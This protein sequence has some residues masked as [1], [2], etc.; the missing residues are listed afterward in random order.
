VVQVLLF[1]LLLYLWSYLKY[2]RQLQ[3]TIRNSLYLLCNKVKKDEYF[4][5]IFQFLSILYFFFELVQVLPSLTWTV[6][7]HIKD[8]TK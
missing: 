7:I 6:G 2:C 1:Y 4:S 5:H 3:S 8:H